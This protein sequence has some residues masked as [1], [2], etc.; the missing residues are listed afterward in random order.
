MGRY[1]CDRGCFHC[2]FPDCV[3]DGCFPSESKAAAE[4]DRRSRAA[5]DEVYA[6]RR[7]YQKAYYQAHKA[8]YAAYRAAYQKNMS[9]A[10]RARNN[11][12]RLER[13][14]ANHDEECAKR[15]ERYRLSKMGKE[16]MPVEETT[17]H[18]E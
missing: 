15:R 14:Y 12:K 17:L 4:R 2:K 9:D 18:Q 10:V 1:P 6:K 7:A 8:E 13:Y 16:R 11:A 5:S 3:V